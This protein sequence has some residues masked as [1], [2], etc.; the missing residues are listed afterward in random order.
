MLQTFR[1]IFLSWKWGPCVRLCLQA[2]YTNLYLARFASVSGIE[3]KRKGLAS[4]SSDG[5]DS[6]RSPAQNTQSWPV[7]TD[8]PQLLQGLT[9][10]C[11]NS[12][13]HGCMMLHVK[14]SEL[15]WNHTTEC[16]LWDKVFRGF[17]HCKMDKISFKLQRESVIRCLELPWILDLLIVAHMQ[18]I[19]RTNSEVWIFTWPSQCGWWP[20][21]QRSSRCIAA[22]HPSSDTAPT[23]AA[24][25]PSGRPHPKIQK[26]DYSGVG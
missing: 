24:P 21:K 11:D 3:S 14:P 18:F 8:K 2:L 23:Q 20:A 5:S 12:F 7:A 4:T 22:C 19:Q 15:D 17:K 10:G 6:W 1:F 16:L 26:P 13:Q 9:N 25:S